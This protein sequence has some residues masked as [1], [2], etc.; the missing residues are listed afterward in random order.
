MADHGDGRAIIIVPK[1]AEQYSGT[2]VAPYPVIVCALGTGSVP[3]QGVALH[4]G[5]KVQERSMY[6]G[7]EPL[8]LSTAR[9]TLIARQP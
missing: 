7:S 3:S 4:L 1:R 5:M 9:A 8:I 2:V 6:A